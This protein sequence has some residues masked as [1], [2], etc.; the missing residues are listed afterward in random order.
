MSI[1]YKCQICRTDLMDNDRVVF[2]HKET[3]TF[4]PAGVPDTV[5]AASVSPEA[6]A[7]SRKDHQRTVVV[8][9]FVDWG[10]ATIPADAFYFRHIWCE[11]A[12]TGA[13]AGNSFNKHAIRFTRGKVGARG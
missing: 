5:K 10:K 6:L 13:K 2:S 8:N 1:I 11:P 12:R 7:E 4:K 9:T 3:F